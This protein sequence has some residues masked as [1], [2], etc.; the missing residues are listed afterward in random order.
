MSRACHLLLS[1]CTCTDAGAEGSVFNRRRQPVGIACDKRDRVTVLGISNRFG[2]YLRRQPTSGSGAAWTY[3]GPAPSH[4]ATDQAR[5]GDEY[6]VRQQIGIT[7]EHPRRLSRS[8]GRSIRESGSRVEREEIIEGL[9]KRRLVVDG[10]R[11]QLKTGD[12]RK[13]IR[14]PSEKPDESGARPGTAMS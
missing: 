5:N 12:I 3:R 10:I 2:R 4:K 14:C 6:R 11:F 1:S 13:R 8:F 7:P 9:R